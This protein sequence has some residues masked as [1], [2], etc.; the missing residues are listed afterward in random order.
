[1]HCVAA[2]AAPPPSAEAAAP[3]APTARPGRAAAAGRRDHRDV[4][5]RREARIGDVVRSPLLLRE[6][7]T[8]I[9]SAAGR[10]M[11]S[12]TSTRGDGGVEV[13]VG[14][15]AVEQELVAAGHQVVTG[16]SSGMPTRSRAA[17]AS[18]T[19][20]SLASQSRQNGGGVGQ[21]AVGDQVE[22]LPAARR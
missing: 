14:R 8:V 5:Q 18:G 2:G 7:G 10:S 20:A 1:M 4:G 13:G 17:S 11:L 6:T 22:P 12:S 3:T 21:E 15:L 19:T 16:A 9:C